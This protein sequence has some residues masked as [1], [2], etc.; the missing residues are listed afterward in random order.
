MAMMTTNIFAK[1]VRRE[2][3]ASIVY[4]DDRCL[5]FNDVNPQAPTHILVIPKK[6]I[7]THAHLEDEDAD[8]I[9]HLHLVAKRIAEGHNLDGYRLVV[10][11]KESAGQTV[12]H[13]HIHLLAG[14]PL[15]WPPG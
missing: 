13:L 5:A 9:G 15:G 11:C 1:I 3:P 2:I 8:L 10:N 4:E 7:P 12:P 14:R 6:E